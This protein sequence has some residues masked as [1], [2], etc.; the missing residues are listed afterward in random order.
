MLGSINMDLMIR[1]GELPRPGETLTAESAREVC[2]G[3]GAN[4]A[5]AAARA[6]GDVTMIGR[7]GDDAFS[8]RLL[9]NLKEEG[10]G[11]THVS[12]TAACP[13]GLAIVA[14]DRNGENQIIVVPGANSR[15]SE[16]DVEAA[17]SAIQSA[18]VLLVQLEI[19][20]PPVEAAIRIARESQVRVILDPAPAPL[21][22]PA[23]FNDA[24]VLC[25]N[26]SEAIAILGD[27]SETSAKTAMLLRSTTGATIVMTLGEK[28]A[29]AC[30]DEE[31]E[32]FP[33]LPISVTDTTGAGDAFAGVLAVYL[34]KHDDIRAA[35]RFANAAGA[36]SAS[37]EGAQSGMGS[38]N[39]I[40]DFL[41][42]NS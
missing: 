35:V 21:A 37:R 33:S 11:T 26:E 15:V 18:D 39:E 40:D 5:V 36:L 3:K 29:I 31:P 20:T 27:E 7:V 12:E 10:I 16:D 42:A 32:L 17:K 6:G 13:S 14:V 1:C 2:G 30:A 28:G 38:W 4:Q 34:A 8:H 23:A 24:D 22:W 9:A 19:P 25:P 41:R